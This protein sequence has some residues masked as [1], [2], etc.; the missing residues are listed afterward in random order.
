[1]VCG[2]P[3]KACLCLAFS[4][5]NRHIKLQIS[6]SEKG[7]FGKGVFSRVLPEDHCKEDPCNFPWGGV[8][9]TS[10]PRVGQLL[11]NSVYKIL[12]GRLR[13]VLLIPTK[14]V[15]KIRLARSWPRTGV[16]NF[17]YE[18]FRVEI[19]GCSSDWVV[20]WQHPIFRIPQF[21][22]VKDFRFPPNPQSAF[23]QQWGRQ[24]DAQQRYFSNRA[25]LVAIVSQNFLVLISVGYCTIIARYVANSGFA[26]YRAIWGHQGP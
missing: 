3:T 24:L 6:G 8:L 20:L 15:Y 22:E 1:M 26:E 2:T 17:W 25:M 19:A 11:S 9:A 5:F 10:W 16:A 12:L 18:H 21:P 23:P 4:L 13:T 7:S 14:S